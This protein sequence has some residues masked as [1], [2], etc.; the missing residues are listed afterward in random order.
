[1]QLPRLAIFDMDGLLFDTERLYR[2][3]R[4]DVLAEYGY[5]HREEDYAQ[6]IGLGGQRQLDVLLRI[7]GPDYPADEIARK[8]RELMDLRI[9]QTGVPVKPGIR[10]LLCFF[11]EKGVS[12][13]V[14]SSTERI[15]VEKY[16]RQ[17]GISE[18][19]SYIV[20][21]N[22]IQR[23]KPEPDIFLAACAHFQIAPE[24]ALVLED[25][26]NGVLA[27]ERAGIPVV[28]I[29]D[30]RMPRKEVLEKAALLSSAT[31]VISLFSQTGA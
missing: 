1:M 31:E 8:S 21:G 14:A 20:G 24:Q 12:C 9:R 17:T 27:A 15:H 5:V 10:E 13:C 26:E 2:D 11:R 3:A 28:C 7:Y 4:A 16:L 23:S 6:I 29:P 22:E 18:Y 19:F 25:S 30:L